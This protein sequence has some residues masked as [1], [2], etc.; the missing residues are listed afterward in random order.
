LKPYHEGELLQYSQQAGEVV[1]AQQNGKVIADAITQKVHKFIE[2]Q[3][4]LI[5][6]A[7]MHSRMFGYLCCS[8]GTPGCQGNR[9]T[10]D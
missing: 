9:S 6:V 3:P 2:Q 1:E 10:N 8:S 5:L 4:M 7:W